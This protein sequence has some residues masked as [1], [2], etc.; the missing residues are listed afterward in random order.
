MQTGYSTDRSRPRGSRARAGTAGRAWLFALAVALAGAAGCAS[1]PPEPPQRLIYLALGASDAAGLGAEPVTRGYVYEITNE[2]DERIDVVLL[3]NLG[4]P[5]ATA[6]QLDGAL[7][8]FLDADDDVEPGLVTV[9]TGANDL[10]NGED[11]DDFEDEL[12][13]IF[14]RLRDRTDGVIAV[15]NIPN[16]TDLPRFRTEPDDD[17]T[18]ER[19]EEFN[20]AIATQAEDHG[21]LLVDL[22]GQDVMDVLV[23]EKDGFH[24]NN[25]GHRRIADRFLKVILPALGLSPTV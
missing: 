7:R 23:S 14:D 13:D 2:L 25:A 16:L 15:A 8:L 21:V 22:F 12:E 10:I 3:A 17:V 5:A 4:V 1:G 20:E 11:V 19:I 18:L 9:W 6:E 24:P